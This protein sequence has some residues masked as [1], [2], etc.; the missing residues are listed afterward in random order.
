ME[1]NTKT[2][3]AIQDEEDAFFS[4]QVESFW[5]MVWK[6]FRKHKLAVAGLIVLLLMLVL[7]FAAPLLTKYGYDE[8]HLEDVPDGMPLRPNSKYIFGTDVVGRDYFT[9]CLYG[10]RISLTVGLVSTAI[11]LAIGIPLG[12]IAG[13]YGGVADM[14]IMRFIEFLACIP[15]FPLLLTLNATLTNPSIYLVMLIIGLLGWGGIARHVRGQ[16]L[17][18]K[19]QEFVQGAKAL[20]FKDKRIIFKHILPH[21]LTPVII[22]VSMGIAGAILMESSLSY[23]GLGV[24]EPIPSWGAM[25]S[26]G[27][28]WLRDRPHLAIIPGVLIL[29]VSLCCNFIGDGFRDALDPRNTRR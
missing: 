21:A 20:G 28:S 27:K 6:R 19:S 3:I 9:R 2:T 14:I 16:F 18:L 7:C 12:C 17:S 1:E 4:S 15:T 24:Q 10:G 11:T 13:Y 8:L 22:S 5:K 23:L 26:R 29:I 25:I